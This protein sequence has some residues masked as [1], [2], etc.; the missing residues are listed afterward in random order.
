MLERRSKGQRRWGLEAGFPLRDRD[1]LTVISERRH[2]PDRRLINTSLG[3]R[4]TM[5]AEMPLLGPEY[6]K[7][8]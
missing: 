3:K 5:Y 1:G 6:K 8:I 4:L 7:K 2:M